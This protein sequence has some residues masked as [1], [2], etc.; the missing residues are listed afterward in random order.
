MRTRVA[1]IVTLLTLVL[2]GI[3][4]TQSC[5]VLAKEENRDYRD[6]LYLACQ[7]AGATLGEETPE[8]RQAGLK[9]M[10]LRDDEIVA[11]VYNANGSV[12][13]ATD[14]GKIPLTEDDLV[15]V[16]D[17]SVNVYTRKNAEGK[18]IN[19]KDGIQAIFTLIKYK[20]CD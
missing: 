19:W 11:G 5:L 14:G 13:F 17:G 6:T 2:L 4:L 10:K 7:A 1:A 15:K 16:K 20:F 9:A 8:G 12:L 18:K 3:L